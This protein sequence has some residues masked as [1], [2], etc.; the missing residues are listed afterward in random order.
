MKHRFFHDP[1]GLRLT[2]HSA[3]TM[4]QRISNLGFICSTQ[5][6]SGDPNSQALKLTMP[7]FSLSEIKLFS[8]S[9]L[10]MRE[11]EDLLQPFLVTL[12][13]N[14]AAKH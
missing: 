7:I 6:T 1:S 10:G 12:Y 9:S 8:K 11:Q 3:P 5:V 13:Q 4:M 14:S 2:L